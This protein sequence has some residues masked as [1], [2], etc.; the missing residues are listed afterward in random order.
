MENFRQVQPLVQP[1]KTITG[2]PVNNII[3]KNGISLFIIEAG[4][5]DV[6]RA[7]FVFRAG[8]IMETAPP[9]SRNHEHDAY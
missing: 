9:G 8:N 1:V 4:T 3:L 6:L 2:V 7:E 5:E